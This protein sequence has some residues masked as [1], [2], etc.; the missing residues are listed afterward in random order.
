MILPSGIPG[1]A[2]G[3]AGD[4][5]PRRDPA[6]RDAMARSLG[7]DPGWAWIDQVHGTRVVVATAPGSTGEADA[8][9]TT[10]PMLPLAVGTADCFPVALVG[11]GIAGLAHAGWRGTLAGVVTALRDAM[12]H[13]TGS[14]PEHAAIG[15]GIGPCC[16]EVGPEV[17][18]Q[19]PW[20]LSTTTSGTQ[21]VDLRAALSDQ[22]AGIPTWV[23]PQC[24][25][26]GEGWHSYRRDRT[27]DRQ[28]AVAWLPA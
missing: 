16:F 22:L 23:A 17:A 1:V 9:L 10:I 4:G 7:I 15:P 18:V 19:F 3:D 26:C 21:S 6:A 20:H 27:P 13:A 28:V 11:K 25:K 12:H 14:Q 2:F 24:T 8:V 5:D